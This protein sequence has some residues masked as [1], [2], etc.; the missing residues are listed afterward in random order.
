MKELRIFRSAL[1]SQHDELSMFVEGECT[2]IIG[3][4]QEFTECYV[5]WEQYGL[6]SL[7]FMLQFP[8]I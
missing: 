5:D 3:V 6:A 2:E 8:L 7:S 1:Q 4:Y